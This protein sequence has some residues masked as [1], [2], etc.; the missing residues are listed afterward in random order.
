MTRP[1][2]RLILLLS[3]QQTQNSSTLPCRIQQEGDVEMSPRAQ[4]GTSGSGAPVGASPLP[5]VLQLEQ[6]EVAVGYMMLLGQCHPQIH[7]PAPLGGTRRADAPAGPYEKQKH[8]LRGVSSSAPKPNP[9]PAKFS[10]SDR[11]RRE[12]LLRV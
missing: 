2:T 6:S 12:V 3:R 1:L 8:K 7:A 10:V 11:H 5:S 4:L 9:L